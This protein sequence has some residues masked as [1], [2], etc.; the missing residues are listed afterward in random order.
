MT[1]KSETK[2]LTIAELARKLS[3]PESTARYYCNRFAAHLSSVGNGRRKRYQPEALETL[4]SI[5][6][7]M[8]RDKSAFAVDLALREAQEPP[9]ASSSV[10]SANFTDN[11]SLMDKMLSLLEKQT[12]ALLGIAEALGSIAKHLPG[13]PPAGDSCPT[14]TGDAGARGEEESSFREE[15]A[16]LREEIRSAESVHQNDLEQLRKWLTRIGSSVSK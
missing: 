12:A 5:T 7:T 11:A 8:R 3:L 2:L 1:Q 15:I 13:I 10:S 4:R 9:S 14:D 6:A 16:A